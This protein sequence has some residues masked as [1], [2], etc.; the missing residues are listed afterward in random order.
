MSKILHDSGVLSTFHYQPHTD[1]LSHH[2]SQPNEDLIL[3]RNQSLRNEPEAFAK[4][5]YMHQLASIPL[6]MWDNAIRDGY[7]LNA[8]DN[9]IAEKELMRFL[10]SENGKI[11]LV[12]DKM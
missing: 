3:E 5:D 8:P 7:E 1:V 9:G 6:I 12:R 10:R 4:N 2:R 11:C